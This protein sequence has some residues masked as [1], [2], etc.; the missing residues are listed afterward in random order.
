MRRN[1]QLPIISVSFLVLGNCLGVGVLAL[2]VKYGL[3][4]FV[5]A[6]AGIVL[7]W[8]VM[9]ASAFIIAQKIGEARNDTFDIPWFYGRELGPAGKWLAIACNLVLLYGVLTA[10]LSGMATMVDHLFRLP[11][12]KPAVTVLYFAVTTALV[13]FGG[14]IYR[15]G[16]VLVIVSVWICFALLVGSG[17]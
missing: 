14:G 9:L 16:N 15:K 3:A 11:V 5:P 2:P 6:L 17:S 10:Y 12:S 1:A 7:A 4:G 13:L 8:A